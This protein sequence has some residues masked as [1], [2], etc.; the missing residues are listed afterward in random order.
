MLKFVIV[1]ALAATC[2]LAAPA[3]EQ[4]KQLSLFEQAYDV[5]S[6]CAAESDLTTCLKLR[7]LGLVERA[8]RSVNIDVIDGLRI[9]QTE[10]AKANSRDARSLN[11]VEASLPADPVAREAAVDDALI[12]RGARFLSTH[13]VEL[14]MPKEVSRAL[15]ESRGKKKKIKSL[16]PIL[17]LLKLKAAALIP[18]ALAGLALLAFKA[19]IIGKIAL[20]ISLI[21]AFQKL[22]GNK[23]Q[24]FDVVAHEVPHHHDEHHGSGWGR[25][26]EMAYSAHKPE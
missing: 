8:S 16:I 22:F 3:Q 7:A 13:T 2:A 5:Y 25:S 6:S 19:V 1:F 23:H 21:L 12:E 15:D 9:V 20:V 24:S 26:L 10:E 11:E 14:S 18:I 4:Q 17:L